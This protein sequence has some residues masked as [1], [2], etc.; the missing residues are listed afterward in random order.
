MITHE[1]KETPRV[2]K[3]QVGFA[4]AL[5]VTAALTVPAQIVVGQQ[6]VS[7]DTLQE[8]RL[9]ARSVARAQNVDT[10]TV[11]SA[12]YL[13]DATLASGAPMQT[14]ASLRGASELYT[15]IQPGGLNGFF[16]FGQGVYW[17]LDDGEMGPSAVAVGGGHVNAYRFSW[18]LHADAPGD[19]LTTSVIVSF[20][21]APPDPVGGATNPVVE[22]PAPVSSIQW[23]FSPIVL[24]ATGG[25]FVTSPVID[26]VALDFDFNLDDTYYV[27]VLPLK[28]DGVLLLLDPNVHGEANGDFPLGGGMYAPTVTV[29]ANQDFMW[30]DFND[31]LFQHPAELIGGFGDG[32]E[33]QVGINLLGTPCSGAPEMALNVVSPVDAC[34]QPGEPLSVILSMSCIPE[35]VRGYQ[36][37]LSF[38]PSVLTFG[39]GIYFLPT[40]FGLPVIAPIIAVGGD[41]DVAAGID[42]LA[43]QP[44]AIGSAD[45]AIL[46]FVTGPLEGATT[47]GFRIHNPPTRFSDALAQELLPLTTSTQTILVD[48][49]PPIITCPADATIECDASTDPDVNLAL[50]VASATDNLDPAPIIDFSDDASGLVGCDGTGIIVRTWSATDCA[51]N[52]STCE[53]TI[54]VQDTTDPVITCPA[55]VTTNA[56]VG[57]CFATPDPGL[58]T[59]TDNC[60]AGP[61]ITWTRSDGGLSLSAPYDLADS[62]VTITWTA[63]DGCGNAS[64]CDQT[65]TVVGVNDLN[66]T[67]ELQPNIDTGDP[68]PDT[69]TRCITFELWECPS[70]SPVVVEAE[71]DF[72]VT[73]PGSG[74]NQAIAS[75]V[76]QIPC[77]A[78]TC[79]TA[80]DALHTLRR[81]LESPDFVVN[82]SIDAFEA[83]FTAVSK[84]LLGGNLNDDFFIDILDFGIFSSQFTTDFGTGDTTCPPSP[85]HAD[86]SGDGIVDNGDFSFIQQN[87]LESHEPNCCGQ[88]G[89][90]APDGP[91][92]EISVNELRQRGLGSLIVADLNRDGLLNQLDIAA[93]I[94]GARPR[95]RISGNVSNGPRI[96]ESDVPVSVS[97][98]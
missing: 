85:P 26:L 35:P 86:I 47:V 70:V 92:L 12:Q 33:S 73:N 69:L 41:I 91:V 40:P 56:T 28:R 82:P 48:G 8:L 6:R 22:P 37:F 29:G 77:G 66:V 84:T 45:L 24:P 14:G 88:A 49:T 72:A 20:Y 98:E 54:T 65:V 19:T 90:S 51:G 74:P 58:A 18:G 9:Q 17:F 75:A 30:T 11:E 27:E 89:R 34:A 67:I 79:I 46:D 25:Y 61:V 64:N 93:F 59:A 10:F 1:P 13:G 36:A 76:V 97:P 7:P 50:G 2:W 60:D 94:D 16:S 96:G 81:T 63:T 71:L 44:L 95:P 62:P 15:G 87:F 32:F 23:D 42:D 3:T 4:F 68:V 39:S 78:Y 52:E 57:G 43:A 31:F 55:D 80:R 38:D 5:V 83:D 21:N 53:Q